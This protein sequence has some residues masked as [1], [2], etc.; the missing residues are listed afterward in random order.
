VGAVQLVMD[1]ATVVVTV[2]GDVDVVSAD[3][4]GEQLLAAL[5]RCAVVRSVVV[6]LRE[7]TF[8]DSCGLHMLLS[9]RH[10]WA[11][12]GVE[13]FLVVKHGSLTARLFQITD[14]QRVLPVHERMGDAL[15]AAKR[16]VPTAATA[17]GS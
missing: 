6:D 15:E 1:K 17:P 4:L 3:Q 2:C 13:P 8:L 16:R 12:Q 11:A 7:V 9:V 5:E 10:R 14:L